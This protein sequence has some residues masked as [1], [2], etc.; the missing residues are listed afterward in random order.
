LPLYV[1]DRVNELDPTG[2]YSAGLLLA[3]ISLVILVSMTSL[4]GRRRTE[5]VE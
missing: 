2:A 1:N 4:S 3:V 5:E